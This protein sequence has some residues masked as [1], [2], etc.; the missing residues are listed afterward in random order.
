M[1]FEAPFRAPP[2]IVRQEWIDHNGHLNMAY[3]N[4]L[5]DHAIDHMF[6]ALGC[7]AS[8]VKERGLSFFTAE[9][10]ICYLRELKVGAETRTTVQLLEHD[11][12][13]TRFY[14]ELFHADGWLSATSESVLLHVDM[15]GPKVVPFPPDVAQRFAD[16]QDAHAALPM[17][18]RAGRSIALTRKTA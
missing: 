2:E 1:Q 14:Q 10:H 16:L 11:D 17:P 8:Y 6:E 15:N 4:V 12:R 7:G 3:Y 18:E 5:F 13:K 9:T